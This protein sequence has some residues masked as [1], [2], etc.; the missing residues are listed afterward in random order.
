MDWCCWARDSPYVVWSSKRF[1]VLN[2]MHKSTPDHSQHATTLGWN[3]QHIY[4]YGGDRTIWRIIDLA[5]FFAL[6]PVCIVYCPVMVLDSDVWTMKCTQFICLVFS[7]N[8]V[9]SFRI[10]KMCGSRT[11]RTRTDAPIKGDWYKNANRR[12]NE[13]VCVHVR[14]CACMCCYV[15]DG[16]FDWFLMYRWPL[17]ELIGC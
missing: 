9:N 2:L 16:L 5:Y 15:N 7:D 1:V 3:A 11:I 14:A 13:W 6:K 8:H 10:F 17:I 4:I 12:A